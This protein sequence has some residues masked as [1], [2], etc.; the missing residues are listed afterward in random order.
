MASGFVSVLGYRFDQ[1]RAC[2][3]SDELR[4][5]GIKSSPPQ[6]HAIIQG[7][8]D[9]DDVEVQHWFYFTIHLK[10]LT[11]T[12]R[13][14]ITSLY[15]ISYDKSNKTLD[16]YFGAQYEGAGSELEYIHTWVNNP[17]TMRIGP[18][19]EATLDVAVPRVIK[20]VEWNLPSNT[21]PENDKAGYISNIRIRERRTD[22]SDLQHV[23]VH[24]SS[25][26]QPFERNP[27][28]TEVH[29]MC[30]MKAWGR[31]LS[32]PLPHKLQFHE[33]SQLKY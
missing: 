30:R 11:S 8:P 16:L 13:F 24:L 29:T 4:I 23:R 32:R 20:E 6:I 26:T 31:K 28:E 22:I 18:N 9:T 25:D 15:G 2:E 19:E 21:I 1:R 14:I 7:G 17:K 3:M 33:E 10:N 12:N 27:R 5:V